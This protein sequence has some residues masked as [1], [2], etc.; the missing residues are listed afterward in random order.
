MTISAWYMDNVEGD[1]RL[2]HKTDETV[3]LDQL[4]ALGVISYEGLTGADDPKLDQLKKER[5]YTYNDICTVAPDKLPG[6]ETKILSF[7]TEHI[8]YD[9]EIRFC[10]D[11]TGY[12]DV[13]DANDRWIRVE[14]QKGDLI[15]L[16]EGVYHRFT[17]T[18]SNYIEAMRLFVGEPVWTPYNRSD[19]TPAE[20]ASRQKY[21]KNFLTK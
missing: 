18:E 8:H 14:L 6:Y 1:Q 11:G 4:A 21:E 10:L 2:P 5:G 20:N 12:F 16:P 7:F 15:I 19:I 9:E 13:R 3:S 17:T